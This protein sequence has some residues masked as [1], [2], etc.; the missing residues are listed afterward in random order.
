MTMIIERIALHLIEL[1]LVSPF[2]TSFGCKV[3]RPCILVETY[4]EGLVGWGE[5]PVFAQ[6]LFSYETIETAWWMLHEVLA[7][8]LLGKR[9]DSPADMLPHFRSIRGHPM[10]R[11]AM[12]ASL[13]DMAAAAQGVSLTTLLGGSRSQVAVGI[14]L[15]IEPTIDA[16]LA[17]VDAAVQHGYQR[18]KL[19]I[20]PGW[21]VEPVRQVRERWQDVLL[22]VDANAAYT[23]DDAAMFQELDH[24]NLLLIEQPLHYDDLVEHARL[25]QTLA[26]PIC[27]DESIQSFHHARWALDSG[28]C[29]IINIKIA[30]VGGMSAALQIHNMCHERDI[31][32]WCGGMLETNVGRAA[33]LALASLPQFVLPADIS[34]SRRYYHRDI[35]EPDFVL[36]PD[37][38]VTVPTAQ[39]LGVQVVPAYLDAARLRYAV[40]KEG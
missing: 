4:A 3:T 8:A 5:C 38:T 40:I 32:V 12:E 2:E 30:R 25:Q 1:P 17:Q 39:G 18:V 28:A 20:K 23:L 26:T 33:N 37:S 16:L 29:G 36:N 21:D 34:A 13:W 19:K 10:A 11:A 15:G 31:P 14:S 22:Q 7:P 6:P 35:A 24:Y 9:I 27:L